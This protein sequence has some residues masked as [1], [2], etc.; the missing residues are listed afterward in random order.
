MR[1]IIAWEDDF[2][3]EESSTGSALKGKTRLWKDSIG[4]KKEELGQVMT[5]MASN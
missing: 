2:I 4:I 3:G 5:S 1:D